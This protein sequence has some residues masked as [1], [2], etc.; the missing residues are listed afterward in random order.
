[1]FLLDWHKL[2]LYA[3]AADAPFVCNA[4]LDHNLTAC[5]DIV[6]AMERIETAAQFCGLGCCFIGNILSH[7]AEVAAALA[8]PD[9][10]YPLLLLTLGYPKKAG[11]IR[12]KLPDSAMI[13][14]ERYDSRSD[15]ELIAGFAQKYQGMTYFLPAQEPERSQQLDEIRAAL[16]AA[17]DEERTAAIMEKIAATGCL[18]EI[19]RRF[20]LNYKAHLSAAQ[21]AAVRR[22]LQDAGIFF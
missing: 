13:F 14:E 19:Q 7:R 17:Y 12:E 6:C 8:L 4:S 20:T 18:S 10:T 22:D 11:I 15:E 21:S 9:Q 16:L 1:V 3:E 2:S 5:E